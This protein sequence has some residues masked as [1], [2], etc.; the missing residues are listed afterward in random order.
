MSLK[1]ESRASLLP[2]KQM[3]EIRKRN[4]EFC[5]SLRS[6]H[7]KAWSGFETSVNW[8]IKATA[9]FYDLHPISKQ[10]WKKNPIF[11]LKQFRID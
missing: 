11:Y 10:G 5:Q 1:E 7:A 3:K 8:S 4:L 6:L 9:N 2:V